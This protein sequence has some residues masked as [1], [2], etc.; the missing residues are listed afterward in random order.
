[1]RPILS[2]I[3]DLELYWPKQHNAVVKRVEEV[4]WR[5]D[6]DDPKRRVKLIDDWNSRS[7]WTIGDLEDAIDREFAV[8]Y[9]GGVPRKARMRILSEGVREHSTHVR[10][11]DMFPVKIAGQEVYVGLTPFTRTPTAAVDAEGRLVR[12]K[13]LI[14]EAQK[15]AKE[16]S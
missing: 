2:Y 7:E 9:K 12:K 14:E 10:P 13:S 8:I 16:F 1:M 3:E 4:M 5:Q 6:P 15:L 11:E